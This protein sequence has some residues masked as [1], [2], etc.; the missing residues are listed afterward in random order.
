MFQ[1]FFLAIIKVENFKLHV[2]IFMKPYMDLQ[3]LCY[4]LEIAKKE[5]E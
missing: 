2:S 3:D 4:R 5:E 1:I